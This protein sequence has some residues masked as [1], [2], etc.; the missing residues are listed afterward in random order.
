MLRLDVVPLVYRELEH[1]IARDLRLGAADVL[2]AEQEL[3]VQVRVVNRVQVDHGDIREARED[4]V[5]D[6]L[7]ADA[8]GA[9]DEDLLV[10]HVAA[11]ELLRDR[12]ARDADVGHEDARRGFLQEMKREKNAQCTKSQN[13]TEREASAPGTHSVEP[14]TNSL[15][16]WQIFTQ[17]FSLDPALRCRGS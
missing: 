17:N 8:T 16:T 12:R 15:A 3:P 6:K 9:D 1:G 13:N 5:L 2:R 14:M 11:R 7:A 4:Q 10:A